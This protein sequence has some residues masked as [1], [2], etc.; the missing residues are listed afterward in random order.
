MAKPVLLGD[1]RAHRAAVTARE[2]AS[3]PVAIRGHGKGR[4]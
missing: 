2:S 3:S 1:F 4:G